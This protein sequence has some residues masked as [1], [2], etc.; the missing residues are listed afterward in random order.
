MDLGLREIQKLSFDGPVVDFAECVA[1]FVV[2]QTHRRHGRLWLGGPIGPF[3]EAHWLEQDLVEEFRA[4]KIFVSMSGQKKVTEAGSLLGLLKKFHLRSVREDS[5]RA[6][7]EWMEGRYPIECVD[8]IPTPI[9]MLRIQCEGR[10]YVSWLNKPE[11]FDQSI[12]RH[13]GSLGF[14]LHDLEHADKFFHNPESFKGQVRFFQLLLQSWEEGTWTEL[15]CE[16]AF[17]S[18]FDYVMSDMNS[19][20]MH[21]LKYLKAIVLMH[22]LRANQ[23]SM[24]DSLSEEN[25]NN[26]D[27]FWKKLFSRWQMSERQIEAGVRLNRPLLEMPD[28][29]NLIAQFFFEENK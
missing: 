14:L 15:Y 6:L 23:L 3:N 9:E 21:L 13:Q 24:V 17:A 2:E 29:V 4:R 8:Y 5:Q 26:L 12:G 1:W 10:R 28:D 11:F 20:P 16:P 7:V 19:H 18:D 27:Q 25:Q 22:H